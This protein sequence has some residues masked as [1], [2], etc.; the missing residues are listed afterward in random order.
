MRTVDPA[1]H[2]AR[3]RQIVDAAATVFATKGFEGATT[4]EIC[5]AAGISSGNLFHY[6]PNKRAV[7]R[8]VFEEDD[9]QARRLADAQDAADPW[10]ALLDVV[11][12]LAGPAADPLT[13]KLVMEAMLQAQR[14]PELN[15]LL[16]GQNDTEHRTIAA[17]LR[18]AADARQIDPQLDPDDA[19][20]WV[21]ALIAA[22]YTS[23]ATNPAFRPADQ[24]PTL[25][26]ILR[27]FLVAAE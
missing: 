11:D 26:L 10:A 16:D 6:F 3:R 25:R 24:L 22:L 5:R 1:K 8:A 20:A 17:L 21:T 14:D 23:A 2:R 13:P 4:A 15:A 18:R 9:D 19:A 7:F 12:L 27:R